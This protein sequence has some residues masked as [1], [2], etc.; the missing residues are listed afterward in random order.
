MGN[1]FSYESCCGCAVIIVVA[2][3]VAAPALLI[4]TVPPKV[5]F[6]AL[7]LLWE[8]LWALLARPRKFTE[9]FED[10]R[11]KAEFVSGKGVWLVSKEVLELR[12]CRGAALLARE[13]APGSL[14]GVCEALDVGV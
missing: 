12:R 14:E 5:W 13:L 10:R 7:T 8:L 11:D 6:V 1:R 2:I 4:K 9:A 3:I